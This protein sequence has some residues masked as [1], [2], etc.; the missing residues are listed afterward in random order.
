MQ[1]TA[2]N[3]TPYRTFANA[4]LQSGTFN[5]TGTLGTVT[6]VGVSAG[7]TLNMPGVSQTFGNV[8]NAGT[9]VT[10]GTGPGTTLTVANYAA[11]QAAISCS[12]PFWA[13]TIHR[14]IGSV[15]NGGTATG[16]DD[17]D[18]SQ[19]DG[20]MANRRPRTVSW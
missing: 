16:T 1:G 17:L 12:I 20:F 9:I 10:S 13:P 18:A 15:V 6:N 8:T 19:H 3:F 14:P 2:W 7:A 5:L 11:A 4:A